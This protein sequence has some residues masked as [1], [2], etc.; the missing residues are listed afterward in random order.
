M[1]DSLAFMNTLLTFIKK[2]EKRTAIKERNEHG[3]LEEQI[4]RAHSPI[5]REG[6]PSAEVGDPKA[7]LC[8]PGHVPDNAGM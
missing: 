1:S 2:K 3:P 6:V 8:T 4:T 7:S 5:S